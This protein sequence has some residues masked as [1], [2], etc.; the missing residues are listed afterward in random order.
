MTQLINFVCFSRMDQGND[1]TNEQMDNELEKE[2]L[3]EK[4]TYSPNKG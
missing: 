2:S 3:D 1:I 4:L